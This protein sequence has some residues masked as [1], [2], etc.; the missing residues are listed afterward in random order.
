MEFRFFFFLPP[1]S[2]SRIFLLL[3]TSLCIQLSSVFC[4]KNDCLSYPVVFWVT[5]YY[6]VAFRFERTQRKKL[7]LL[8]LYLGSTV[9][10]WAL[11][12]IVYLKKLMWKS[13]VLISTTLLVWPLA[14]RQ[15]VDSSIS[16]F[17]LV[18]LQFM[19]TEIVYPCILLLKKYCYSP[20]KNT[21]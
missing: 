18:V 21:E 2:V 8:W 14:E 10:K 4:L 1:G 17:Q 9:L 5:E 6:F 19:W 7:S 15:S 3:V 20:D 11:I 13:F 12:C 16:S